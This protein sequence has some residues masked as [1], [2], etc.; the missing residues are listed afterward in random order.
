MFPHRLGSLAGS[1]TWT[2]W[3][4]AG[5]DFA[6][7]PISRWHGDDLNQASPFFSFALVVRGQLYRLD[8]IDKRGSTANLEGSE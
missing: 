8:L 6:S 2:V 1:S 4:T 5:L 7:L 3:R